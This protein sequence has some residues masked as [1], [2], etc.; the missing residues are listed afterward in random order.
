MG[1]RRER[2]VGSGGVQRARGPAGV[3]GDWSRRFE[4]DQGLTGGHNSMCGDCVEGLASTT[5]AGPLLV[6][7]RAA[8]AFWE[9]FFF[10]FN[11]FFYFSRPS[12]LPAVC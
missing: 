4:P 3:A 9:G 11:F 10:F 2:L 6:C 5:A 7:V 1:R 8:F 12:L